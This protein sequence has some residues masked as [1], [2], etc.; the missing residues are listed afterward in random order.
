MSYEFIE[1][2]DELQPQPGSSRSGAPPRKSTLVGVPNPQNCPRCGK[3]F[4]AKIEESAM[5]K[6]RA[7]APA[8]WEKL[9]EKISCKV[10]TCLEPAGT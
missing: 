2:P 5:R 9:R 6:T 3:R 4:A 1:R 7:R 8:E 10:C